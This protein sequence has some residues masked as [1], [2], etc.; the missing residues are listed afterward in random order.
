[1]LLMIRAASWPA[2]SPIVASTSSAVAPSLPSLRIDPPADSTRAL[3]QTIRLSLRRPWTPIVVPVDSA[4]S[5]S[6]SQVTGSASGS[7]PASSA[8]DRLNQ[9][10]WVLP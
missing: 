10:S 7:I 4:A 8:T 3:T 5:M 6:W 1:M 2:S 9:S